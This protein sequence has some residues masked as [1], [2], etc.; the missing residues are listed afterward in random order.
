MLKVQTK[1]DPEHSAPDSRR[2]GNEAE[3]PPFAAWQ[4]F[5]PPRHRL[6]PVGRLLDLSETASACASV[7]LAYPGNGNAVL[8]RTCFS[9]KLERI[10]S[11]P[12]IGVS[13]SRMKRS[14]AA[15]SATA[16]RIR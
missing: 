9:A 13:C 14:S 4:P 11:M 3:R 15:M 16:T 10:F 7:V 1:P 2:W 5:A 6:T 12:G 8:Y